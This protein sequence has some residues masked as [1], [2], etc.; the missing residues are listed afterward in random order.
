[1][2][3]NLDK[4]YK[5]NEKEELE[6][7]WFDVGDGAAFRLKRYGG[8][9]ASALVASTAKWKKPFS[10]Q[11]EMKTI[12]PEK[13]KEIN[14]RIFVE[15]CLVDWKGIQTQ[16]GEGDEAK[17]VEIPFSSDNALDLFRSLPGLMDS[18][19]VICVDDAN[20]KGDLVNS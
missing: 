17:M 2:K 14:I 15:T 10:R 19:F 8:A 6:G 13:L 16:Q 5:T 18:L 20:Y 1:M 9:N 11:I 7:N 3:T 4:R 12:D